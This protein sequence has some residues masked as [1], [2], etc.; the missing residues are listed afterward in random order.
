MPKNQYKPIQQIVKH[1][2]NCAM[3][4]GYNGDQPWC[5]PEQKTDWSF[6]PKEERI[7]RDLTGR[8][9]PRARHTWVVLRCSDSD[10][11]AQLAIYWP[12]FVAQLNL[13]SSLWKEK[14][15]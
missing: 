6:T 9:N 2:S 5:L 10:C 3:L 13:N 15:A 1:S 11:P 7:G 8:K 4:N 14:E 12:K